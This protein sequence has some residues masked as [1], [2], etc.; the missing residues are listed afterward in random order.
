M[1]TRLNAKREEGFSLVELLV[2]VVII[3]ILAAVA[4]PVYTSFSDKARL[5]NAIRDGGAYLQNIIGVAGTVTNA[6]AS[7]ANT[8]TWISANGETLTWGSG[9]AGTAGATSLDV[10]L[11][12]G[13]SIGDNG[14]AANTNFQASPEFCFT[15]VN[16]GQ[17]A[18]FNQ[19]G[20]QADATECSAAG[21]AS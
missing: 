1:F 6:G 10:N 14:Y 5:T 15:M 11:S 20:Y 9:N 4:I 21:V 18:V 3:G 13:S 8:S 12:P 17:E 2:V 16:E 19:D 7:P